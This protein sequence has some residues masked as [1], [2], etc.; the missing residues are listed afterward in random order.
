MQWSVTLVVVGD[1]VE[2]DEG[3]SCMGWASHPFEWGCAWWLMLLGVTVGTHPLGWAQS[4]LVTVEEQM[5]PAVGLNT[6]LG[7]KEGMA[8]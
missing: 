7:A 1:P 4:V 5:G 2:E 3:A 6:V 8:L